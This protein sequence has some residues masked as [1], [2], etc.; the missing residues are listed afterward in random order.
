MDDNEIVNLVDA[1]SADDPPTAEEIQYQLERCPTADTDYIPSSNTFSGS[2]SHSELEEDS[3]SL[4]QSRA[5]R[6][7][8]LNRR[9]SFF[10]K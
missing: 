4:S 10:D 5:K 7:R 2:D 6:K 8:T 3:Q 1:E 9:Y